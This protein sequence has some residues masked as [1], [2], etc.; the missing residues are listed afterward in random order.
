M[1][2]LFK[3]GFVSIVLVDETDGRALPAQHVAQIQVARRADKDDA[4]VA[5]RS[6]SDTP[7]R[8]ISSQLKRRPVVFESPPTWD[9]A[10]R[11]YLNR[12]EW[13]K[14]AARIAGEV[15]YT[16]FKNDCSASVVD[17]LEE[18][19]YAVWHVV[20]DATKSALPAIYA[21]KT[22]QRSTRRMR[23]VKTGEG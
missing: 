23:K 22:W 20:K 11:V 16:N 12:S 7:V 9:Y 5:V 3:Q 19:A 2:L 15:S 13:V 17:G 10:F 18:T 21:A 4:V 1:Y 8:W 6:R 14:I